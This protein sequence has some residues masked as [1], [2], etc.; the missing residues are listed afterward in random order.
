MLSLTDSET[1]SLLQVIERDLSHYA[2]K[3]DERKYPREQLERLREVFST[4]KSVL[5]SDIRDALVWK[6]GH[7]G[8]P[9]YPRQHHELATQI[10]KK[11]SAKPMLATDAPQSTFQ[12]WL[13]F[14]PTSFITICFLLH[15]VYRD[16]P[17]LDQ[18]NY[19]SVNLHLA[20]VRHG[21][22]GKVKPSQFDD[23]LLVRDFMNAVLGAWKLYGSTKMPTEDK[24]K[25]DR[26]LM[27]HGKAHK[28]RRRAVGHHEGKKT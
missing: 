13:S 10:A 2:D 24:V 11:W 27:M 21:H 28:S 14:K 5:E 23:L 7:T 16:L 6:Y 18:H 25:L 20:S 19:R 4:P 3:Y 12:D 1:K 8:K 15:L 26:Y 22:V 17:I 9:N